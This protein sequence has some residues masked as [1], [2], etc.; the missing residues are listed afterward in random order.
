MRIQEVRKSLVGRLRERRSEIE[1]ATLTRIRSIS[2][3]AENPDSEYS[4]GLPTVVSAAIEYGI[5]AVERSEDRPLP[6]P[7][8]L[9]S[10]ARLAARH[11]VELET[12]LR[13]YLAGYTLLG[14]FLIE[15]SERGGQLKGDSL[16]RLLR[17]QAAVLDRLISAVSEE[18]AREAKARPGSTEQRLAARVKQLLAGELVDTSELAYDFEAWHLGFVAS[19]PAA[20]ETLGGIA[21]SL[22][23][24]PLL[25]R[26]E[27]SAAWGWLGFRGRPDQ[28][29]VAAL[30]SRA[31]PV[32][33]TSAIGEPG[34][35]IAGW[36]L[37]HRQARAALPIALRS[38][39]AFV[40]YSEVALVASMFRDDLLV[41][42]LREIYLLPLTQERDGGRV[43]RATLGAYFAAQRNVSSAAA[44]LGVSRQAV[45]RRL[46]VV[47]ER[48]GYPLSSCAADMEAALRLGGE[49]LA[50]CAPPPSGRTTSPDLPT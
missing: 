48:I 10:Q 21:K 35:G 38:G 24:R 50:C 44:M 47:E 4:D 12:V 42:S 11:G 7:T 37:T 36:R 41:T 31:F 32:G 40:R 30:A 9:L 34:E 46:R 27:E 14:D 13:R 45:A 49:E 8:V 16:K 5:A 33:V 17:V 3:S 1:Q 43:A 20:A 26:H 25:I 28:E 18:Y 29:E 2:D 39:K 15:E 22:G 19:G 23:R 6:I